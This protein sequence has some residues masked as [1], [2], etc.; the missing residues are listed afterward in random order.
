MSTTSLPLRNPDLL[1]SHKGE[2]VEPYYQE[3]LLHYTPY[4]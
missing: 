2:T 4:R 1:L 3:T